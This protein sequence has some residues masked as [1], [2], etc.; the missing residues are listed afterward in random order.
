MVQF[1]T[2]ARATGEVNHSVCVSVSRT[3]TLQQHVSKTNVMSHKIHE[4]L[5]VSLGR[6][7]GSCDGEF[8]GERVGLVVVGLVVV[9]RLDVGGVVEMIPGKQEETE[10]SFVHHTS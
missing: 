5:G 9:I 8:V 2:R 6:I 1:Q 3:P 10:H 4:L 7:V